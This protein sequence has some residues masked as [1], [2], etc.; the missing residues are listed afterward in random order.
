MR[1]TVGLTQ[2]VPGV[3]GEILEASDFSRWPGHLHRV[4]PIDHTQS[5]MEPRVGG[6]LVTSPANP[7]ADESP[8]TG[9]DRDSGSHGVAIR[10]AALQPQ[11][12]PVTALGLV[13]K[14]R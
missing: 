10:S 7:P 12:Q 6:R 11:R 13:V 4:D 3:D 8:A 1:A 5:E 9:N 2:Q 14:V